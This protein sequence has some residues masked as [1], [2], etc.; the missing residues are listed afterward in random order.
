MRAH[1]RARVRTRVSCIHIDNPSINEVTER[2]RTIKN[3]TATLEDKDAVIEDL[4]ATLDE[5]EAVIEGLRA[6]VD[7]DTIIVT[8]K[9]ELAALRAQVDGF[10]SPIIAD[11]AKELAALRAQVAGFS[12]LVSPEKNK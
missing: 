12:S 2:G 4:T 6:E 1:A 9:K 11:Q 7:K 8:Q 3:L 10:V 5:K